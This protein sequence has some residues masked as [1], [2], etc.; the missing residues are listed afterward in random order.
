M[1]TAAR[2]EES[3]VEDDF[4]PFLSPEPPALTPA[5]AAPA[6]PPRTNIGG[7]S[8]GNNSGS[9]GAASN[10]WTGAN[11]SSSS[12]SSSRRRGSSRGNGNGATPFAGET[13][14]QGRSPPG[15]SSPPPPYAPPATT[16]TTTTTNGNGGDTAAV[17][18]AS[19]RSPTRSGSSTAAP[20]HGRGGSGGGSGGGGRPATTVRDA[21]AAATG[22]QSSS[23]SPTPTS[24][25]PPRPVSPPSRNSDT[26]AAATAPAHR[27]G[28]GRSGSRSSGGSGGGSSAAGS[29]A[30]TVSPAP[31]AARNPVAATS[32]TTTAT[33]TTTTAATPGAASATSSASASPPGGRRTGSWNWGNLGRSLIGAMLGPGAIGGEAGGGSGDRAVGAGPGRVRFRELTPHEM[34][35]TPEG[36]FSVSVWRKNKQDAEPVQVSVGVY[37]SAYEGQRAAESFSPPLWQEPAKDSRC[38]VCNSTFGFVLKRR[39]H[40]RNCGRLVCSSCAETFWPKN[41]LPPT[42][43]VDT[44][45]RKVRVCSTCYGAGEDFRKALL[46]GSEEGA[47]AAYSTG[48][49]NLRVPYTI[50]HNELPVHCAAAGGNLNILAWLVDDRC[51]PLFLDREKKIA[52]G[53]SRR[54]SVMGAAAAA[55]HIQIMRYLAFTQGCK[56]T[57]IR[58]MQSLWGALEKCLYDGANVVPESGTHRSHRNGGSGSPSCSGGGGGGGSSG[59]G[60]GGGVGYPSSSG[61]QGSGGGSGGAE[62]AAPSVGDDDACIV[63][64]ERKVDCTL[65]PCGHHCCCITCAAQFEQCPVCR[66]DV[67]QKIRA[68][69]AGQAEA[70]GTGRGFSPVSSGM[71][72][73]PAS[74][75]CVWSACDDYDDHGGEEAKEREEEE[76]EDQD[77]EEQDGLFRRVS[78]RT[79]S[80]LRRPATASSSSYSRL[81]APAAWQSVTASPVSRTPA[82]E[83]R[84]RAGKFFGAQVRTPSS[85]VRTPSSQTSGTPSRQARTPFAVPLSP[86]APASIGPSA[87]ASTSFAQAGASAAAAAAARGTPRTARRSPP[88]SSNATTRPAAPSRVAPHARSGSAP[89]AGTPWCTGDPPPPRRRTSM[90]AAPGRTPSTRTTPAR[91]PCTAVRVSP[92]GTPEPTTA[93]ATASPASSPPLEDVS[94]SSSFDD[95]A[96]AASSD[97]WIDRGRGSRDG[98]DV[99]EDAT[100]AAA[101]AAAAAGGDVGWDFDEFD[102]GVDRGP[103]S[104]AGGGRRSSV[105]L[106][107]IF[108]S[109]N[110]LDDSEGY[111]TSEDHHSGDRGLFGPPRLPAPLSPRL[112][113]VH[114]VKQ[115]LV[116]SG[117]LSA[118]KQQEPSGFSSSSSGTAGGGAGYELGDLDLV[119][120][121]DDEQTPTLPELV[122]RD[123]SYRSA[124][125]HSR[126]PRMRRPRTATGESSSA[127]DGKGVPLGGGASAVRLLPRRALGGGATT[128]IHGAPSPTSTFGAETSL[129]QVVTRGDSV[130]QGAGALVASPPRL[131]RVRLGAG[132]R[133]VVS[134]ARRPPIRRC[135]RTSC[136]PKQL[137]GGEWDGGGDYSGDDSLDRAAVE[138]STCG[139]MRRARS[140]DSSLDSSSDDDDDYGGGIRDTSRM[141]GRVPPKFLQGGHLTG[142]GGG[143]GGRGGAP[144]GIRR[145]PAGVALRTPTATGHAAAR[146]GSRGVARGP[147][148]EGQREGGKHEARRSRPWAELEERGQNGR[149]AA[150]TYRRQNSAQMT[151]LRSLRLRSNSFGY[152]LVNALEDLRHH[153]KEG[154]EEGAEERRRQR[155]QRADDQQ[156]GSNQPD[157]G[158]TPAPAPAPEQHG[159]GRLKTRSS[160]TGQ[161]PWSRSRG[162]SHSRGGGSGANSRRGSGVG[163]SGTNSR[164]ASGIGGGGGGGGGSNRSSEIFGKI[165]GV[166]SLEPRSQSPSVRRMSWIEQHK[167]EVAAE[168]FQSPATR[169]ASSS[170]EDEPCPEDDLFRGTP[171]AAVQKEGAPWG[172]RTAPGWRWR[173]RAAPVGVGGGCRQTVTKLPV[174]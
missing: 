81:A 60:G 57:E 45:E 20:T 130:E 110:D 47:M 90:P 111:E 105:R 44:G 95:V 160:S 46:S 76:E 7:A 96:P 129:Y 51:C 136:V 1:A 10:T 26:P 163:G 125:S 133:L 84:S 15:Q 154:D 115:Q 137:H 14:Q 4:N 39:H 12:S 94:A 132:G 112:G 9:S 68:I 113:R 29:R 170:F 86:I 152:D 8:G 159:R 18:G 36:K 149:A 80:L 88:S 101:V 23:R 41:M 126:S 61:A 70:A 17:V 87:H 66:A 48:C 119:T 122:T 161:R 28:S 134:D 147:P 40:C 128:G 37:D 131:L 142:H 148:R 74:M 69:S 50:Y 77:D 144:G 157:A 16:T 127:F 145:T 19:S 25:P 55:G 156:R 13:G 43:S 151:S 82:S 78:R 93:T 107:Q 138:R 22:R 168:A 97:D 173:S 33:T 83:T 59:G 158:A 42:Y 162:R 102:Y 38:A 91:A 169:V 11:A 155:P 172:N 123:S 174:D 27:R 99:D 117:F 32:P 79:P 30:N 21:A 3:D 164:R 139:D 31:P 85:Q 108:G 116:T 63:C 72:R 135:R 166:L 49:V 100:P 121:G 52:L 89:L 92:E 118:V 171:A 109:E 35:Q 143:G 141:L 106:F 71:R 165:K 24:R 65:V 104:G 98:G 103:A 34:V 167:A 54:Q 56:V 140:P 62:V 114:G 2:R 146:A 153:E 58:N 67:E 53:D 5:I 124:L 64:F 73:N 120:D 6:L 75:P 150:A